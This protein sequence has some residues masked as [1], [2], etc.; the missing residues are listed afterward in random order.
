MKRVVSSLLVAA[1]VLV[2]SGSAFAQDQMVWWTWNWDSA[3]QEETWSKKAKEFS[4]QT[5]IQVEIRTEDLRIDT[6]RSSRVQVDSHSRLPARAD[7][8]DLGTTPVTLTV[9]PAALRVI[10]PPIEEGRPDG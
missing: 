7:S 8:D 9:S 10:A 6:Y 5:G 4:E 1:A 2:A 3:W